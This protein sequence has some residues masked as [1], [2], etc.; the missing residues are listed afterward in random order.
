[1]VFAL[2][3]TV[4]MPQIKEWIGEAKQTVPDLYPVEL[5]LTFSG[6]ELSTNVEEPYVL[7]LPPKWEAALLSSEDEQDEE[8]DEDEPQ[9][10]HLLVIDTT[11]TVEE[12]PEYETAV[13]L[14]KTAV[15]ARDDNGLRV[16]FYR[17][18]QKPGTSPIIINRELYNEV[19]AKALPFLDFIPAIIFT[20]AVFAVL[21]LPWIAAPFILLGYLLYLLVF[22]LLAWVLA[23]IMS[24]KFTYGELYKLGMYGLTP[25]ILIEW[26]L[27][28]FHTGIAMLFSLIFLVTMGIVI[29]AFP[30]KGSK[31]AASVSAKSPK[32]SKR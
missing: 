31:K 20:L 18:F 26:V 14:T 6:A 19:T 22:T 4:F 12:Y 10:T 1:M 25:A 7:P 30:K 9:F 2:Q 17:E 5:V 27:H 16:V 32:K 23:A 15:I 24:R 29:H 21:L 13:L 11:A 28:W 3:A 8:D